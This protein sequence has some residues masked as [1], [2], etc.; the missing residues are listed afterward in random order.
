M[1]GVK[2][3]VVDQWIII[4]GAMIW[5]VTMGAPAGAMSLRLVITGV[6]TWVGIMEIPAGAMSLPVVITRIIA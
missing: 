6:I 3:C 5:A 1:K 2:L 4:M